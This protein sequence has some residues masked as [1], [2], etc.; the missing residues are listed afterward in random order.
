VF[1]SWIVSDRLVAIGREEE[2]SKLGET[3]RNYHPKAPLF[4]IAGNHDCPGISDTAR[5]GSEKR[6]REGYLAF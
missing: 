6:K 1:R 4:P 5:Q 3:Y 2:I